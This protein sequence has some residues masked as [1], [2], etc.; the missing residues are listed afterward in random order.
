MTRSIH[1]RAG[2]M[3]L[4]LASLGW[5]SPI[6]APRAIGQ[7]GPTVQLQQLDG[8]PLQGELL[9]CSAEQLQIVTPDGQQLSLA[10]EQLASLAPASA[11]ARADGP[12]RAQLLDGSLLRGRQIIGQ[13]DR[14]TL[15][16]DQ[17]QWEI[18]AG[19]L[20]WLL[21]RPP[22]A[23]ELAQWRNWLENRPQGDSLVIDRGRGNLDLITGLIIKI[24]DG[25]VEFDFDGEPV[26]APLE[27]LLGVIWYRPSRPSQPPAM[28]LEHRDGSQLRIAELLGPTATA[29][30]WSIEWQ[31]ADR[32]R[33]GSIAWDQLLG[34][35]LSTA[36]VRWLASLP[37]L[38][39]QAAPR[40]A[41]A[42]SLPAR[43]ELLGPRFGTHAGRNSGGETST[44][45]LTPTGGAHDLL[46]PGPGQITLR[47]PEG[48]GRL[49]TEATPLAAGP[50]VGPMVL[51]VLV[52]GEVVRSQRFSGADQS[53]MLDMP[54]TPGS[55]LTLRLQ[56]E[57]GL[58]AGAMLL[59]RQPRLLLSQP[60]DATDPP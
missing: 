2:L 52:E 22:A 32:S 36:N 7:S 45:T 24:E 29:D 53:T 58:A 33:R 13:Q 43:E 3:L 57:G 55:R 47:V 25:Q 26:R 46:F 14:W 16:S 1:S 48:W 30:G 38:E 56:A 39:R 49:I 35:D 50:H 21:L 11:P 41:L 40:T 37:P 42:T 59:C 6:G 5:L 28:T 51:D 60:P 8:Q 54:V 23:A 17:Q 34:V 19:Q 31:A 15:Q 9:R 10:L 27:R 18:P 4:S 20:D 12:W 44:Q